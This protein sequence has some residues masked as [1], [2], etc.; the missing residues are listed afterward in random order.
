[1]ICAPYELAPIEESQMP[2][3]KCPSDSRKRT[4]V[5]LIADSEPKTGTARSRKTPTLANPP[6]QRDRVTIGFWIGA[7]A[8]GIAGCVL[9]GYMPYQHPVATAMSIFWWG[10]FMGCFGGS[11]GGLLALTTQERDS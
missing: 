10:I 9:G 4:Y 2:N 3:T 7:I 11:L 8:L 1:M 5:P 6:R